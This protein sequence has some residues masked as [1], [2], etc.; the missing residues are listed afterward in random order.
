MEWNQLKFYHRNPPSVTLGRTPD[1]LC[2]YDIYTE[3]LKSI[4]RSVT[5]DVICKYLNHDQPFSIALNQFPYDLATNIH[6]FVVWINPNYSDIITEDYIESYLHNY[7]IND[8]V[9]FENLNN[10]KSIKQIRH[11]QLFL[12]NPIFIA[13]L[14]SL[15]SFIP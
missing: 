3:Y 15:S 11:Y 1:V 2:S 12:S 10:V 4:N 14:Q 8:Y 6:H 9:L 13:V 5:Q 7:L